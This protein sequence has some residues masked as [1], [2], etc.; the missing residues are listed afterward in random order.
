[1]TFTT[2]TNQI[3]NARAEI[4]LTHAKLER[5]KSLK[6]LDDQQILEDRIGHLVFC[7]VRLEEEL[8]HSYGLTVSHEGFI[9]DAETGM[10]V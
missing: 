4:K 1:M 6:N 9:C 5:A 8:E 3:L 10:K 2:L 7:C